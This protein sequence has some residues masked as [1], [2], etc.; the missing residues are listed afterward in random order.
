MI[1]DGC[2]LNSSIQCWWVDDTGG[3]DSFK[4]RME[5]FTVHG[6]ERP[7]DHATVIRLGSNY[8]LG[9][10]SWETPPNWRKL[11]RRLRGDQE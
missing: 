7:P 10:G 11:T 8:I 2:L 6:G 1:L 3:S 4:A 5:A 9:D